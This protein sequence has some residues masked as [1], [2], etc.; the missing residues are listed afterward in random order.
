MKVTSENYVD[1]AIKT[2]SPITDEMKNRIIDALPEFIFLMNQQIELGNKLDKIKKYMYYGKGEYT[3]TSLP[4]YELSERS[5]EDTVIRLIHGV[6]GITT[7]ASELFEALYKHIVDGEPLDLVNISEESGDC[8]WYQAII[9]DVIKTPMN[10]VL[11][12]NLEKLAARYPDK[13]TEES[14]INRDLETERKIL[15]Q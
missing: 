8:Y 6:I 4:K 7:E 1:L 15:E 12:T 10:K 9:S 5:T 3:A 11:Q 13:F 14:A 2:E